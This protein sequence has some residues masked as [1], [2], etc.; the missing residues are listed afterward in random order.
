MTSVVQQAGTS[1]P[2][3]RSGAARTTFIAMGGMLFTGWAVDWGKLIAEAETWGEVIR[4]AGI[5][6]E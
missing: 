1:G 4:S 2:P 5:K 6:A 3:P